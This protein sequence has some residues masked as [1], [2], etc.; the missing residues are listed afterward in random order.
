MSGRRLRN[1]K[2]TRRA[3]GCCWRLEFSRVISEALEILGTLP[4]LHQ[5]RRSQSP[6]S[7]SGAALP[8]RAVLYYV[9]TVHNLYRLSKCN[10]LSLRKIS[11]PTAA[12]SPVAFRPLGFWPLSFLASRLVPFRLFGLLAFFPT[13]LHTSVL[14]DHPRRPTARRWPAARHAHPIPASV[15]DIA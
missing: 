10:T 14:Q 1:P 8:R 7:T 2:I 6:P 12:S 4:Q 13:P 11:K 9:P 5:P 3:P 15:R